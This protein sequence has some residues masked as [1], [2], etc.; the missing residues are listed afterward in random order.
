M[1]RKWSTLVLTLLCLPFLALAQNTGKIS[2]RITD[3]AAGTPIPGATVQVEGTQ[4]GAVSDV[5]GNYF[6]IGVPVG[7]YN[8]R[9]TFVGYKTKTELGVRISSGR[10]TELNIVLAEENSTVASVDIVFEKPLIAKDAVGA[11]KTIS[12]EDIQNL[13]VRGVNGALGI[14]AGISTTDR[15][16]SNAR[17]GRSGEIVYYVDGIRT[18]DL[19]IP[20]GAIS[21]QEMMVGNISARYGDAMSGV[22]NITTKSG[23]TKFF[24]TVEGV[25]SQFLDPYGYNLA[26][27]S[28]GGP[29]VKGK[30]S[31]FASGSYTNQLDTNPSW[32]KFPSVP[33]ALVAEWQNSPQVLAVVNAAGVK[34]YVD[35]PG[36]LPDGTRIKV[37]AATHLPVYDGNNLIFI[38]KDGNEVRKVDL[39]TDNKLY[40]VGGTVVEMWRKGE[41]LPID[42][43][44]MRAASRDN[45]ERLNLRG[46]M[47]FDLS[48]EIRL[49]VG[50]S[51]TT[52]NNGGGGTAISNYN[53]FTQN[54]S[55]NRQGFATLTH[56][57]SNN[58][59]YQ[60]QFDYVDANSVS[61]NPNFSNKVED[62]LFYG[63]VDHAANAMNAKYRSSTSTLTSGALTDIAFNQIA[64]DGVF[65]S[66]GVNGF[67]SMP[68]A[69]LPNFAKSRTQKTHFSAE[70]TTQ[71][72]IHQIQFGAEY[73]QQTQR[74]YSVAPA[75][76]ARLYDDGN[77]EVALKDQGKVSSWNDLV[78]GALDK[79]IAYFG[80]NFLG[81]EET[82]TEDIAN[83]VAISKNST[84]DKSY[85]NTA[86][87]RPIF[88]GGFVQDKIEY[89]D[90]V[91][92][93]GLRADIFDNNALVLKDPYALVEI[94]RANEVANRPS[95]IGEDFGVLYK[96]GDSKQAI[97]GYRSVE[98][99]FFNANGEATTFIQLRNDFGAK[100]VSKSDDLTPNVFKD[101]K[102]RL[103][104]MPRIGLSFPVTDQAL[105]FASY[106]VTS[107]RPS[108]NYLSTYGYLRFQRE[109]SGSLTSNTDLAP[110]RTIEYSLGFRQRLG[111][112]MAATLTGFIRQQKGQ[113]GN[114]KLIFTYPWSANDQRQNV[115]F[116]SIKGV[117][118]EV[119][120][121]RMKGFQ[122]NVNYT[123]SFAEGTGSDPATFGNISWLGG[124]DPFYPNFLSRMN[125]DSRHAVNVSLDYR[126]GNGEGPEIAGM[127]LLENF[128]VNVLGVF[129][130][131][132][133][134]T[135]RSRAVDAISPGPEVAGF[136]V[137]G[138]NNGEM[139]PT[140]RIDLKVD[141]RFA[142][143][144]AN[145][146]A[147]LEVQ[148]LLNQENIFGVY[149]ATGLPSY[150]GFLIE[151]DGLAKYPVGSLRR[152]QYSLI[153]NN[154]RGAYGLPR[155]TRLGL[156]FTF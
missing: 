149:A 37:D 143:G 50:G 51:Q 129:K 54:E 77:V 7:A 145:M 108:S 76:L 90:L 132:R 52:N 154:N 111:E 29:I 121:R 99:D 87:Y 41:V 15:G 34:S 38:D 94:I 44:E 88:F 113:V 144:K 48:K 97:V 30:V 106:G 55:S 72:G 134:Y 85:G 103:N 133:P 80:Y 19:A 47:T 40:L 9:S 66:I 57:L 112:K 107:Q 118:A 98:G 79:N 119:E 71:V 69:F 110:P 33:E 128:G 155:M 43:Y 81:T 100:H 78:F 4:L 117:E 65:A 8:V 96:D 141:R 114:R 148:N 130:T 16:G 122:M 105:F 42:K 135:M 11:E 116:A 95:N 73:E 115:D 56:R 93:L 59:F 156:R 20:Q 101:Y 18:G 22:V 136:L 91:L 70:A 86:P 137:G 64:K 140:S 6:I 23:A 2:G 75:S 152:D 58:T 12:G 142:L 53:F 125:F 10:T 126:I 84:L 74:S 120:L 127:H 61:Y 27:A 46:N 3:A 63:D 21:E 24:G 28:L 104:L 150:D 151:P 147:Y 31:F 32:R 17:G 36:D 139:P 49:R 1:S 83:L 89:K 35:L 39:G 60:L 45:F 124:E 146:V 102:P 82:D 26:E 138:I 109:N 13:P 153:A 25:S 68:G 14:Q 67:Y 123:L 62:A 5:N 92:N 131:G